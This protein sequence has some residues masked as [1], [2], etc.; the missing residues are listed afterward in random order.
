MLFSVQQTVYADLQSDIDAIIDSPK[1]PAALW[2]VRI[3]ESESG[4]V[5]Y[6]RNGNSPFIPASVAKLVTTA[7]ALDRLG[8]DYTFN[9]HLQFPIPE[10][11]SSGVIEGDLQII[12]GGD[13]TFG[14][15]E[16]AGGRKMLQQWAK[17]LKREGVKKIRGDIIGVDDVFV[18]EPL[19]RGWA[20]DDENYAF[21]AHPSGLTVHGGVVG[22]RIEKNSKRRLRREQIQ[23]YPQSE[24]LNP[25]VRTTRDKRRV[26]VGRERGKHRFV[27]EV[28]ETMRKNPAMSGKVTVENPTRWTAMLL[29]K[30]LEQAGIK[31]TG[32]AIDSDQLQKFV[33][34]QGLV[35]SHRSKPLKATLP[36]AH[37]RSIKLVAEHLLRAAGVRRNA[38]GEQVAAGSVARGV[39]AENRFLGKQKIKSY[40]YQL[41][42][43]SGLSRYNLLRP[44]DLVK[45]LRVMAQHPQAKVFHDSLSRAGHDGTLNWRFRET[46][47]EG[48]VWA[49]TGTLSSVRGIA[50]YLKSPKKGKS[51]TFTILV[52]NYASGSRKVRNRMDQ[53]LLK[54]AEWA[55]R[56]QS[57]KKKQK[58]K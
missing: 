25:V 39:E 36:S 18:E 32:E 20:W 46:P 16:G 26:V 58:G 28:P 53:I 7:V 24:D 52:N 19:G 30:A 44:E 31:V 23:L 49:K 33:V 21:S 6:S 47:L 41:A 29:K 13:P 11:P 27:V 38:Q 22:Y 14:I 1:T 55:D 50:G 48:R 17:R 15:A 34:A 57:Q 5:L 8:P 54:A 10:I 40:R 51:L 56:N 35:W 12:G 4:E 3:E 9:T 2:G 37:T 42:D 43:G 45:L